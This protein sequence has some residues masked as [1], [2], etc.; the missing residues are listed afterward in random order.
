MNK[1]KSTLYILLTLCIATLAI[2]MSIFAS[3]GTADR[4]VIAIPESHGT[5]IKDASTLSTLLGKPVDIQIHSDESAL[6]RAIRAGEADAFITSSFTFI[7]EYA[8]LN[9]AKA[10]FG[11]PT[12]YYLVS[13]IGVNDK[14]N[15]IA[16]FDPYISKLLQNDTSFSTVTIY[17]THERIVALEEAYV[18]QIIMHA[19][20]LDTSRHAV[21]D[22]L[23]TKGYTEDLFV[24]SLE[25]IDYDQEHQH[26]LIDA[27]EK[28][29]R[30][31]LEK[32]LEDE[33]LRAMSH[34]FSLE[35][36]STRYYYSD[37]VYG[38]D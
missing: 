6:I 14:K 2:I 16:V 25:W 34:L 33:L 24:L 13:S 32:P 22:R 4:F 19:S 5:L 26:A 21:V 10:V 15:K 31:P 36:I 20:Y 9:N 3:R 11:I 12:D 38:K 37:L 27:L 18:S 1:N 8:N 30:L 17:G 29:M 23:S 28:A 35:T 7:S